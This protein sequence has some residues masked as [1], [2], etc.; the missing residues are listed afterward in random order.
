M[1]VA[2]AQVG[3]GSD[4]IFVPVVRTGAM[5]TGDHAFARSDLVVPVDQDRVAP[6]RRRDGHAQIGTRRAILADV[7]F[8][9]GRR[10]F[11]YHRDVRGGIAAQQRGRQRGRGFVEENRFG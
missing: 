1:Q 7:E 3:I 8:R 2:V 11:A 5:P 9:A 10:R 6:V 4:L